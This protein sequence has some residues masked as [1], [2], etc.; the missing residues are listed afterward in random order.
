MGDTAPDATGVPARSAA[1]FL[2]ASRSLA[3]LREASRG[4]RGCDLYERATQTVFGEGESTADLVLVGEVPG[5]YEDRQG[6]PFVGPAGRLLDQA[7]TAAGI[8]RR[9]VYVTNAVKHFKW[10][11]RGKRR[12]H[13]TP[14][15]REIA[16]CR[17]WLQAELEALRPKAVVALGATAAQSL[18]GKD[19]RVTKQRGQVLR[20][21][22][23]PHVMATVH[24]SSILRAQDDQQREVQMELFIRDLQ[25]IAPLLRE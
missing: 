19:F 20:S 10:I 11:Q 21:S 14:N 7:L 18:L 25:R 1:D 23:A 22:L 16:A 13:Q 9:E 12:I 24:P 8:D 6:R 3:A 5:D 15:Q 17:P 2:P 4:C